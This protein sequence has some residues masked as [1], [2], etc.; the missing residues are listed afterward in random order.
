[1]DEKTRDDR[2]SPGKMRDKK[3][4][5]RREQADPELLRFAWTRSTDQTEKKVRKTKCDSVSPLSTRCFAWWH[6]KRGAGPACDV[7][8]KKLGRGIGE[9]PKVGSKVQDGKR[10][11]SAEWGPRA[12]H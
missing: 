5:E 9:R 3:K 7:R 8:T 6:G 10:R 4:E 12:G 1:M 11:W 2:K